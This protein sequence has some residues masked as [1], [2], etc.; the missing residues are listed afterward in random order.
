MG[1]SYTDLRTAVQ[2]Y[3]E[4]TFTDADFAYMTQLAE[5]KIYNSVH[6]P[7]M[8]KTTALNLVLGVNTLDAPTDFLNAYSMGITDNSGNYQYLIYKERSFM[9]EAYPNQFTFSVPRYYA[10]LGPQ[11]GNELYSRFLVG[12]TPDMA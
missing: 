11:P 3:T 2:D 6:L 8:H 1:T 12:P 10:V 7:I 5:Q 4:N 9:N